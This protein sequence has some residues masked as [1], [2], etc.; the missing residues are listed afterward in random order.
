M[1]LPFVN[2]LMEL[3]IR[4]IPADAEEETKAAELA[5]LDEKLLVSPALAMAEASNAIGRMGALASENIDLALGQLHGYDA[6]V[7][8]SIN[9]REERIDRFADRADNFLIR[10][11]HDLESAGEDARINLLMQAVPDFERIGDYATNINELAEQLN[12]QKVTLSD[13]AKGELNIIGEA[14]SEIVRLT[15]DAFKN[16]DNTAARRVEPLE[17]VIDDMVLQLR[18]NH[19]ERLRRGICTVN[20]GLVFLETLTYLERAADQCSS[21][22][23]L[24]LARENESIKKNH[25]AYLQ[26]LHADGGAEY[27]A[28]IA[29]RRKQYLDRLSKTPQ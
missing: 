1:L 9:S 4:I 23:L 21:I 29:E 15:V 20:G 14:V 6:A 16:D 5:M 3:S 2:Q 27:E 13:Y 22:A 12:A 11:A 10:L 26:S 24:M 7:T 28:A 17:E 19:T 25:H 18:D 8:N